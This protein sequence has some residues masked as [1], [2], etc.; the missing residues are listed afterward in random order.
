[1]ISRRPPQLYS[2]F[3]S[4][5]VKERIVYSPSFFWSPDSLLMSVRGW[6]TNEPRLF[7]FRY[8]PRHARVLLHHFLRT[9]SLTKTKLLVRLFLHDVPRSRTFSSLDYQ[10]RSL[11][12]PNGTS[13]LHASFVFSPPSLFPFAI[14]SFA[15]FSIFL[16]F[17]TL[18]SKFTEQ[19]ERNKIKIMRKIHPLPWHSL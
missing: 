4:V 3:I 14:N 5:R 18:I 9:E 6:I 7:S 8:Q 12:F 16:H 15:Y 2:I 1:M 11:L 17:C 13:A 10:A 19:K